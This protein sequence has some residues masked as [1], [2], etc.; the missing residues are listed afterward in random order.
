ML[1]LNAKDLRDT[2]LGVRVKPGD[3]LRACGAAR[4]CK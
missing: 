3:G 1:N 2:E 4:V